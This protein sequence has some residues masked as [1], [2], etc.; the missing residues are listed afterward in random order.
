MQANYYEVLGLNKEAGPEEIKKAYR[1]LARQ[2]HP[3]INKEPGAEERFKQ[4]AEAYETLSDPE[5]KR[6]YDYQGSSGFGGDGFNPFQDIFNHFTTQQA[7]RPPKGADIQQ[8]IDLTFE[9]SLFG[10]TKEVKYTKQGSCTPCNGT[11]SRDRQS[12]KCLR[13]NGAGRITVHRRLGPITLQEAASCSE[14]GGQGVKIDAA[15]LSCSGS[16]LANQQASISLQIPAGILTGMSLSADGQGHQPARGIGAPGNLFVLVNVK[17]HPHLE[18][19][20]GTLNIKHRPKVHV[21]SNL[22]GTTVQVLAPDYQAGRMAPITVTIPPGTST[23]KKF[24]IAQKGMRHVQH[25]EQIGDL[26]IEMDHI[27]P[28]VTDPS[29]VAKIQNIINETSL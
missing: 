7:A 2:Y 17:K 22:I 8:I 6:D 15:C 27:V 18:V 28:A 23:S 24:R 10:V 20:G 13:C 5:K 19:E 3:D 14:C 16:G 4:I 11:G 21:L 26:I 12:K 1:N 25:P 29:Q 9:E